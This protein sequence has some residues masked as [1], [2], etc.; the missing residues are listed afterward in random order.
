MAI[1]PDP[2]RVRQ[3]ARHEADGR[4]EREQVRAAGWHPSVPEIA[5]PSPA[6]ATMIGRATKPPCRF[7]R[8]AV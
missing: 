6:V 4:G 1:E 5:W 3:P 8:I 2:I 7:A